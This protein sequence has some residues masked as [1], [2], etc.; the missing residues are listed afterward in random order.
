MTA[1]VSIV[2]IAMIPVDCKMTNFSSHLF[3]YFFGMTNFIFV[4]AT[5]IN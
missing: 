2:F 4:G 1:L 3:V 5:P